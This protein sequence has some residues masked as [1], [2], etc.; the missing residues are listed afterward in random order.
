MDLAGFKQDNSTNWIS[1]K[2]PCE[3]SPKEKLPKSGS[4]CLINEKWNL[5]I[6]YISSDCQPCTTEL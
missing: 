4:V 5:F 6:C 2:S 1:D 3:H